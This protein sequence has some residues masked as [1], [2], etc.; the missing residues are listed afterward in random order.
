MQPGSLL[1]LMG[2][3]IRLKLVFGLILP[4][5]HCLLK[6]TS[7]KNVS[8]KVIQIS[9]KTVK[10]GLVLLLEQI[11]QSFVSL[12]VRRPCWRLRVSRC[13]LQNNSGRLALAVDQSVFQRNSQLHQPQR[14]RSHHSQV[15]EQSRHQDTHTHAAAAHTKRITH[16]ASCILWPGDSCV[17]SQLGTAYVS[18]TTG[19]VATA[20]GLNALTKVLASSSNLA[21]RLLLLVKPAQRCGRRSRESNRAEAAPYCGNAAALLT[22]SGSA[23]R[24]DV[25]PPFTEFF[26]SLTSWHIV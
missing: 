13:V 7:S 22:G 24:R 11:K 9:I 16:A 25:L 19:A 14:R 17:C 15:G 10:S 21:V 4:F 3:L 20:L 23:C 12:S 5:Y 18:A 1:H 26:F 6:D 8:S 2:Y